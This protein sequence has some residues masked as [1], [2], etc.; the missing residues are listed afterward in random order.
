MH[1]QLEVLLKLVIKVNIR[2]FPI[3]FIDV[4]EYA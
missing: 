2:G 4:C 3:Y 1:L